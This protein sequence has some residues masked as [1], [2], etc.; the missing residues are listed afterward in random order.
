MRHRVHTFKIGRTSAHRKA[1]LANMVSSLIES[2]TIKTTVVKA[3]EA[4]RFADRM[5][6]LGKKGTLHHRRLAVSYLRDKTAV[7]KLFDEIA[8]SFE[9]RPGG[10]TRIIRLGFRQG[11]AAEMCMLQLTNNDV[12][13]ES[14]KA[15]TA[16]KPKKTAKPKAE[17]SE[18]TAA[19][20]KKARKA[21]AKK[22]DAK[23]EKPAV[24]AEEA[25]AE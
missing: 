13:A 7:K 19:E 21:P 9:G 3:K 10:Y 17:K 6:T 2:G 5:V 23:A 8:P 25:K 24:E 1:M 14:K 18:E 15:D 20:P 16:E 11:D 22:A 4:R 12:V